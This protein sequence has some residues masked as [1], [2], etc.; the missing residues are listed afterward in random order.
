MHLLDLGFHKCI[1]LIALFMKIVLLTSTMAAQ[2][3]MELNFSAAV[4]APN[5]EFWDDSWMMLV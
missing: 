1:V 4:A 2:V 5:K 3:F